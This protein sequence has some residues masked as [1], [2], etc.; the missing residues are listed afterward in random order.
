MTHIS[1]RERNLLVVT[2]LIV[3]YGIIGFS[4]RKQLD[5]LGRQR[6]AY[7]TAKSQLAFERQMIEATPMIQKQ[8][9][10][11]K[12]LMPVFSM[13]K[14]VDTHWLGI[15]DG[16]A[17]K[18]KINIVK[19]QTGK[20]NRVGEVYEFA[21]E[22]REWD[23]RLDSLTKFLYE[24][25]SQGVMLDMRQLFIRPHPQQPG[26]L[27][28]SFTLYCA[29]MRDPNAPSEKSVVSQKE[30]PE[31]SSSPERPLDKPGNASPAK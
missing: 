10:E 8:Y 1:P 23:G 7:A 11:L 2:V 31:S 14:A 18:E 16:I 27:R 30:S 4:M 15:M 24:L 12:A 26:F 5:E 28:G 25:E 19:R 13:E 22:C 29:Y 21:V 20:E 9:D 6:N 17:T 3:L